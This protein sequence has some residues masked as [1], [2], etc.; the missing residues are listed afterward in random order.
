MTS[1]TSAHLAMINDF[2]PY[3]NS[4]Y[5]A[6]GLYSHGPDYTAADIIKAMCVLFVNKGS[7]YEFCGDSVDR[8]FIRDIMLESATMLKHFQDKGVVH[9]ERN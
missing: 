9:T 4:F 8:E 2:I 7:E 6:E 5:G 3:F 1:I